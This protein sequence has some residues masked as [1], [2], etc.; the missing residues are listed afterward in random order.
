MSHTD[1]DVLAVNPAGSKYFL[2]GDVGGTNTRMM[3]K[4]ANG[5]II[6]RVDSKTSNFTDF[7]A[8]LNF[9]L[10]DVSQKPPKIYAA[11][12]FASKI[13]HNKTVTN[14][15][16]S[17]PSTDGDQIKEQFGFKEMVLLNDF[18]GCGYSV[19]I[20]DR[21]QIIALTAG[22]ELPALKG[23]FKVMLVGPGTGLGVCLLSQK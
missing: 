23:N 22:T 10:E 9:F 1:L 18:E 4:T 12:C 16:Y 2:V 17:W 11:V 13:L 6:K 15:N 20:L 8:V 7:A 19:P 14:A 5:D 21:E 3:L